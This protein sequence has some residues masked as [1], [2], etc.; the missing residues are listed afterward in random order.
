MLT[1]NNDSSLHLEKKRREKI[2]KY[3]SALT[4]FIRNYINDPVFTALKP[5]TLGM[6]YS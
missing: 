1:Q 4:F 2:L 5:D 6:K 3:N